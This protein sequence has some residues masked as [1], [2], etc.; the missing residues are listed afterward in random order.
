M[1]PSTAAF[2]RPALSRGAYSRQFSPPSNNPSGS[3]APYM[4]S[5]PQAASPLSPT[6]HQGG[7]YSEPSPI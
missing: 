6:P 7:P 1:A 5:R 4:S 3:Y 2:K